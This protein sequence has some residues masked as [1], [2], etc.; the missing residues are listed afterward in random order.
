MDRSSSA[1]VAHDMSPLR[2]SPSGENALQRSAPLSSLSLPLSSSVCASCSPCSASSTSASSSSSSRGCD[3]KADEAD[4]LGEA[5]AGLHGAPVLLLLVL[6]EELLKGDSQEDSR[7]QES[8][9]AQRPEEERTEASACTGKAAEHPNGISSGSPAHLF[10]R[11]LLHRL[12]TP[13]E[14]RGTSTA[15]SCAVREQRSA[16]P[17]GVVL[18]TKYYDAPV[19]L[20]CQYLSREA[21]SSPC[22][23]L[24]GA[25]LYASGAT[26]L[27]LCKSPAAAPSSRQVLQTPSTASSS[28]LSPSSPSSLSS[29]D[30]VAAA[31]LSPS[32]SASASLQATSPGLFVPSV[33]LASPPEALLVLCA[34]PLAEELAGRRAKK[35]R[36]PSESRE[37]NA[38]SHVEKQPAEDDMEEEL[39]L[40]ACLRRPPFRLTT[41]SGAEKSKGRRA[42]PADLEDRA[43]SA[44]ARANFY[45][46]LGEE[47]DEEASEEDGEET[48]D[49]EWLSRV[50]VK[51][52]VSVDG[53]VKSE[54]RSKC[55]EQASRIRRSGPGAPDADDPSE[56]LFFENNCI[57]E[58]VS[59]PWPRPC[60]G[61]SSPGVALSPAGASSN[62]ASHPA[63]LG[64]QD[65]MTRLV[66]ALHCHLWPNLRRRAPPK[67]REE[68]REEI[69]G[70]SAFR[71]APSPA[72]ACA[73]VSSSSSGSSGLGAETP[74]PPKQAR[75]AKQTDSSRSQTP[76]ESGK[77]GHPPQ[78]RFSE[79]KE[80][81]ERDKRATETQGAETEKGQTRK[82]T[83]EFSE[84]GLERE[85]GDREKKASGN[86]QF[87]E[88][89]S[90]SDS[91]GRGGKA[92]AAGR[93]KAAVRAIVGEEHPSTGKERNLS[94]E[95]SKDKKDDTANVAHLDSLD[96]LIQQ[97]RAVRLE[98]ENLPP[99]ERRAR[100][101]AMA[102]RLATVMGLSE[103]EED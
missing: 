55:L 78:A 37:A 34:A 59:L 95:S 53:P 41:P 20:V 91:S 96:A 89:W 85:N 36:E 81:T 90:E 31:S 79:L 69:S 50:P 1:E 38:R 29:S 94:G 66:D 14:G 45:A 84:D 42:P 44:S 80:A 4:L 5:S 58:R 21:S 103:D 27:T 76:G 83:G 65:A 100:A 39:P 77:P 23:S 92:T 60:N 18:R 30:A 47:T 63:L 52:F 97:L 61:A 8:A 9:A 35:R 72:S 2:S 67:K 3:E 87:A 62:L 6:S 48:A 73:A 102:L 75:E 57:F 13:I 68:K 15:C 82:E 12:G 56:I 33:G 24:D 49:S 88:E 98:S 74:I 10:L 40:P 32:L 86:K 43:A 93:Q 28:A 64:S 70:F 7:G 51:L 19:R 99:E 26:S 11:D 101:E 17:Q 16:L 71:M 46:P 54:T 22:A 25:E